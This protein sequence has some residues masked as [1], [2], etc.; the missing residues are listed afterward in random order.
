MVSTLDS[1]S[2][3]PSSN[4]GGTFL[5]NF[6]KDTFYSPAFRLPRP[7]AAWL[8]RTRRTDVGPNGTGG[9]LAGPGWLCP[10]LAVGGPAPP[11]PS[12]SRPGAQRRPLVERSPLVGSPGSRRV[13]GRGCAHR[14]LPLEGASHRTPC[15]RTVGPV[16]KWWRGGAAMSLISQD[17]SLD[18]DGRSRVPDLPGM[19][20]ALFRFSIITNVN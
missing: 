17:G 4:L 18:Q 15:D 3:D 2:S 16:R 5:F 10:S 8:T 14:V 13:K 12:T 20:Y 7:P 9:V 11:L 1:E 19:N 6:K